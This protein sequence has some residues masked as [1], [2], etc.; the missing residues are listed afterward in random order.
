MA[1]PMVFPHKGVWTFSRGGD[2]PFD[3]WE[4]LW[5]CGSLCRSSS[6]KKRKTWGQ[7]PCSSFFC[8]KLHGQQHIVS[9]AQTLQKT[10][11]SS[12]EGSCWQYH[13]RCWDSCHMT[14]GHDCTCPWSEYKGGPQSKTHRQAGHTAGPW[15][16]SHLPCGAGGPASIDTSQP[17]YHRYW[18]CQ[19][20]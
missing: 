3:D 16:F 12:S 9:P 10:F 20:A 15:G 1:S 18:E 2:R 11:L 7:V 6:T 8:G 17:E 5:R 19:H 14:S 13:T 4:G